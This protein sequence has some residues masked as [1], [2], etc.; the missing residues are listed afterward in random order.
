MTIFE[1]ILL[2]TLAAPVV[3][4]SLI[5]IAATVIDEWDQPI[6]PHSGFCPDS[7]TWEPSTPH[8]TFSKPTQ[9]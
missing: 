9:L 5:W 8:T 4:A 1:K 7:P 6:Y 2:A 3:A